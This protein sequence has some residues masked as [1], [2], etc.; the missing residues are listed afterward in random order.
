[1][2]ER[3]NAGDGLCEGICGACG[4]ILGSGRIGRAREDVVIGDFRADGGAEDDCQ[5]CWRGVKSAVT[6]EPEDE[7]GGG[8]FVLL[9]KG[10]F[11]RFSGV[12]DLISGV[13]GRVF[14]GTDDC[15]TGRRGFSSDR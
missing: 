4:G 8:V 9:G 2:A 1:M 10:V 6:A 11:V 12:L 7:D 5:G 15:D 14:P 13:L 3:I